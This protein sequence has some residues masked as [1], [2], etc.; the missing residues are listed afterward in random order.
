MKAIKRKH[1][2]RYDTQTEHYLVPAALV[3]LN[4]IAVHI[5][6]AYFN[7]TG[8]QMGWLVSLT[9]AFI[10]LSSAVWLKNRIYLWCSMM[11]YVVLLIYCLA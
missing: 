5:A 10:S 8:N 9:L 4:I 1:S 6:Y 3:L 7:A 2:K 11:Y